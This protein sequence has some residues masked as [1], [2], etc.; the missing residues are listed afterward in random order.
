MPF[1]RIDLSKHAPAE[2]IRIVRQG[3][4]PIAGEV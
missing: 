3:V 2:R 1:V 4:N